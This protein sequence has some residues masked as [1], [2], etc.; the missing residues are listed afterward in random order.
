M[1]KKTLTKA[2]Y[3]AVGDHF[4]KLW[5]KEAGWAHSVLFTADLKRFSDRLTVKREVEEKVEETM[6]NGEDQK[7]VVK[8]KA[9]TRLTDQVS[10]KRELDDESETKP[11]LGSAGSRSLRSSKRRKS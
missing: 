10:V 3:E 5:G 6:V 11:I 9:W 2:T 4:R 7:T 8:T 1:N